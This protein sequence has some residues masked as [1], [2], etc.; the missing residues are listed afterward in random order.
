MV[1]SIG[2]DDENQTNYLL[3]RLFYF[4]SGATRPCSY[5]VMVTQDIGQSS[6]ESRSVTECRRGENTVGCV[7]FEWRRI[8]ECHYRIINQRCWMVFV[9]NPSRMYV[10]GTACIYEVLAPVVQSNETKQGHACITVC[11]CDNAECIGIR[12][13]HWLLRITGFVV[14]FYYLPIGMYV[15]LF[16][17][18]LVS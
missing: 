3:T 4:R 5:I 13:Q 16:V 14:V 7:T 6:G 17:Y 18:C 11:C 9:Y 1:L 12:A 15:K 2:F 10:T 8:N